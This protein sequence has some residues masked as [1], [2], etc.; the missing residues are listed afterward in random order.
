MLMVIVIT[1]SHES[2]IP[3]NFIVLGSHSKIATHAYYKSLPSLPPPPPLQQQPAKRSKNAPST[4]ATPHQPKV[5][6]ITKQAPPPKASPQ[7]TPST[8]IDSGRL[9][10]PQAKLA[11]PAKKIVAKKEEPSPE[12]QDIDFED[13]DYYDDDEAE[14]ILLAGQET[15]KDEPRK[16]EA[17]KQTLTSN[18][19]SYSR[20]T[21]IHNKELVRYQKAIQ[22]AVMEVWQTPPG[23][24]I[25]K[26]TE[27]TFRFIIDKKGNVKHFD[28]VKHSNVLLFDLSIQR[29]AMQIPFGKYEKNLCNKQII[30]TFRE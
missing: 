9:K 13:E 11:N 7:K 8:T 20:K 19:P 12:L 28:V 27:C 5:A 6:P 10:N 25:Q 2:H 3:N 29:S 26:G 4:L 24:Q 14:E 17:P 18:A 22:Q 23:C 15:P 16:Q 30:V 1:V 21:E